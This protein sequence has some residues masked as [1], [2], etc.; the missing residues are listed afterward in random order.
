MNAHGLAAYLAVTTS[1]LLVAGCQTSSPAPRIFY[2][3]VTETGDASDLL[4]AAEARCDD[5]AHREAKGASD[6][7]Y[8]RAELNVPRDNGTVN[9]GAPAG[10]S[11]SPAQMQA[12]LARQTATIQA[13]AVYRDTWMQ[14]K[15]ACMSDAGFREVST[16]VLNCSQ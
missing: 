13:N 5:Q 15:R 6:R 1:L 8:R 9:S 4:A 14:V 11:T 16:C 7:E 3:P 2:Q 10:L 12:R